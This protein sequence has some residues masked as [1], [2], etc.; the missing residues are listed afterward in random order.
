[1]YGAFTYIYQK[2]MINVGKYSIHGFFGYGMSPNSSYELQIGR[3]FYTEQ[4]FLRELE[5]S[6]SMATYTP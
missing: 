3:H 6:T 4:W 5:L 2:F 1:M